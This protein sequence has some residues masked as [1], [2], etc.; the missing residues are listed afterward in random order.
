MGRLRIKPKDK[1]FAQGQELKKL[2]RKIE[3]PQQLALLIHQIGRPAMRQAVLNRIRPWLKFKVDNL[4]DILER[5]AAE[6]TL[7]SNG[8][9]NS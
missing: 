8:A 7:E 1:E 3:S 2:A 6:A 4:A 9:Q 5:Q